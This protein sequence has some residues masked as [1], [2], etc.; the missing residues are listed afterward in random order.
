M[1]PQL[2]LLDR[3]GVINFDSPDY[4]KSPEEWRA[5]PGALQ[6]IARLNR[7]GVTVAICSN[8][9]GIGRGLFTRQTLNA[10][11]DKLLAA[12]AA[13]GGHLNHIG[14]CPHAPNADCGCRKPKP[15]LLIEAL[16]RCNAAAAKTVFIGDSLRDLAAAEAAGVLPILV[17]TG[18]GRQA[19][20]RL[21]ES[22]ASN[23]VVFDDLA[24]AVDALLRSSK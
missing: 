6:A 20:A 21:Q 4:I 15:G 1:A 2:V 3:D 22:G 14:I 7:A 12:L 8:Q 23:G 17:R 19:E 10:I 9:S 24:E 13:Q 5:L 11:H 18:N 16:Q